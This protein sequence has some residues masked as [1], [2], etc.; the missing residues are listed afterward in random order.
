VLARAKMVEV[1][2]TTTG[3]RVVARAADLPTGGA[4]FSPDGRRFATESFHLARVRETATGKVVTPPLRHGEEVQQVQFSP[5]G[6]YLL[7]RTTTAVRV[8]E[9][10][11]GR[12]LT[13]T[14]KHG[15]QVY[16]AGFAPDGRRVFAVTPNAVW[17]WDAVPG[18]TFHPLQA[19]RRDV[20]ERSFP[21]I[22]LCPRPDP[23][24]LQFGP[25]FSDLPQPSFSRDG[26][27]LLLIKGL[28]TRVWDAAGGGPLS[29]PIEH[30]APVAFACF[31][32]DGRKVL[33]VSGEDQKGD[34]VRVWSAA[35]GK[36]FTPGWKHAAE[37]DYA[38]FSPDGQRVLTLAQEEIRLGE[39]G[40]GR[41]LR[42]V[43][44]HTSL[45]VKP[46]FSPDG[47]RL[48]AVNDK[49]AHLWD[50]PAGR[51]ATPPIDCGDAIQGVVF[52]SDRL[53][54]RTSATLL[55]WDTRTGKEVP[56]P[57]KPR[58]KTNGAFSPDGRSLLTTRVTDQMTPR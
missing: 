2:E 16:Q 51:L 46:T 50:V 34:E 38:C 18:P 35:T 49:V 1:W 13:P 11:T 20:R 56:L 25:L 37:V 58:P 41:S 19:Q 21:A 14:L 6:R 26:R 47:R 8:W 43:G 29:P 23:G 28:R 9:V 54:L 48:L 42:R 15:Q 55:V 40:P 31:S 32:P 33:T 5:D 39:V 17:L 10:A 7:T 27:R 53:L 44:P 12:P 24:D 45:A 4:T 3:K 30:S 52:S 57:F 36:P 22:D